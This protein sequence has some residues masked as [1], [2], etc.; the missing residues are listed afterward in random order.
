M[1]DIEKVLKSQYPSISNLPN[2]AENSIY[3]SLKK[4][5]YQNEINEFL[6]KNSNSTGMDF[7]RKVLEHFNFGYSVSNKDIENIPSEGKV[8]IIANHPLGALDSFALLDLVTSVRSDVRI[9][10]NSV[11]MNIEPISPLLLPVDN[12]TG[13][14]SKASFKNIVRALD[15]EEAVIFFPSGEVS[16]V[17]PTGIKDTTWRSGFLH[18][19]K[20]TNSPILPIFI[21]ARNSWL[22]YAISMI[23]KNAATLLLAREMF[24]KKDKTISFN[25][26]E[27]VPQ[28]SISL[29]SL[30]T[31][32][33][34]NLLK[35]HLYKVSK[36]KKGV[37]TT[38]KCIAHQEDRQKLKKELSECELLGKTSD[39]KKI[40][41][42]DYDKDSSIIRELGRLR[43]YSFR[44]V[45]EG[46]GKKRDIDKYDV[47]YRHLVLWDEDELEIVGAYRLGESDTIMQMDEGKDSFYTSSL[48]D[49]ND[50]FEP[51]L[52]NSIE[53]G[54]S[55]VQPK[56]WGSRALDYLWFGIGAYIRTRPNLKY[57]FG[58][59]SMSASYPKL[60][61]NL[62][63]FFYKNYFGSD[64]DI[65][66]SKNRYIMTKKE[67]DECRNIFSCDD[68]VA[69]F[70]V[71]KQT[72]SNMNIS[73]PTLYRQYS[74]L[75]E[76]G[77]VKFLDF[78]EDKDFENCIDGFL[79]LEVEKI[80]DSKRKRYMQVLE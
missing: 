21:N 28:N 49:L 54:R 39:G 13:A 57:M 60:A 76:E 66:V 72:L 48:F 65:V 47:Y 44:K 23:Y 29:K 24:N 55:F 42:A 6:E 14:I 20:K 31:K 41:L 77:G 61:R 58:P 25:V 79:L 26:G 36:G 16:R 50:S 51:Y 73:V 80:K 35:K 69:D 19:A 11:L 3:F 78:G 5:F 38:Q 9:V 8:V 40:Y 22:F 15:N 62:L 45:G 18:L 10:A 2:F 52:S 37:F 75:C 27:L 34:I 30:N 32:T 12:L 7:I 1:I 74:E 43:E 59:V 63:I 53:L 71:L 56:Y 64:D 67:I 33:E 17:R 70:K 46:T 4:L 68:Y